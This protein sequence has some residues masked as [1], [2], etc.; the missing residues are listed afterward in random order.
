[1]RGGCGGTERVAD[2]SKAAP[3]LPRLLSPPRCRHP[4]PALPQDACRFRRF[5]AWG[6][7][8][9]GGG[10]LLMGDVV[11]VCLCLLFVPFDSCARAMMM[12]LLHSGADA[13]ADAA[14]RSQVGADE[15]VGA[16]T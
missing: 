3:A 4:H 11:C 2:P 13:G 1:M 6:A 15:R 8:G 14:V 7:F 9:G 10:G 12:G 5:L 16:Q